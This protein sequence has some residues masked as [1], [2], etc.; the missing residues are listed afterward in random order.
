MKASSWLPAAAFLGTSVPTVL[1]L[2]QFQVGGDYKVWIAIAVGVVAS[3]FAQSR[4]RS[5]TT[6]SDAEVKK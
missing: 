3:A 4:L 2:N 6:S 5:A 1:L